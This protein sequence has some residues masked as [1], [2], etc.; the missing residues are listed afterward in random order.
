[1]AYNWGYIVDASLAKLDL[2]QAEA[3][4]QH[5]I[6]RFYI[7]ANEVITQVCSAIKPKR[8][9]AHFTITADMVGQL[10]T[11]PTDFVSFAGDVCFQI[12][13]L[14]TFPYPLGQNVP[15]AIRKE[16]HDNDFLYQ[17]YN[18]V[19]FLHP[20][21]FYIAYNAR[22]YTFTSTQ[23]IN[24]DIDVPTDILDCIP[25]YIAA[26]CFKIDDEYK[27][28]VFRN[29]YEMFLARIDDTD[30]ADSRTMIIGGDW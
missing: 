20:G 14:P 8:E 29:E 10:Q 16:L 3:N 15:S 28:S 27:A 22:W 2:N 12:V 7:Y 19:V 17:G 18:Q 6:S 4:Q 11:M 23:D 21:D 5:L 24:A 26:Q 13:N 9:F 1:M 25:S 30:Y